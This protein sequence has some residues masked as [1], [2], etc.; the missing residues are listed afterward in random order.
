MAVLL[1]TG[2]LAEADAA[3]VLGSELFAGL[4]ASQ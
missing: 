1:G 3:E 2:T 4:M